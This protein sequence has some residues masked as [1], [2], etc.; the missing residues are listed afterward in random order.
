MKKVFIKILPL[1]IL[2]LSS[3]D[4]TFSQCAPAANSSFPWHTFDFASVTSINYS[5]APSSSITVSSPCANYYTGMK[6]NVAFCD[7]AVD[8]VQPSSSQTITFSITLPAGLYFNTATAGPITPPTTNSSGTSV[9]ASTL[10]NNPTESFSNNDGCGYKTTTVSFSDLVCAAFYVNFAMPIVVKKGSADNYKFTTS[11]A[12][13][14]FTITSN[15]YTTGTHNGCGSPATSFTAPNFVL[16]ITLYSFTAENL[17]NGTARLDWASANEV[18]SKEYEVQSSNN[19]IDF[20]TIQT[21]SSK[22]NAEGAS[23][24]TIVDLPAGTTYFRLKMADR[25]G[26]YTFSQIATVS[27]KTVAVDFRVYPNP[28]ASGHPL[29]IDIS[30]RSSTTSVQITN[31]CGQALLSQRLTPGINNI[32]TNGL[33]KGMYFLRFTDANNGRISTQKILIE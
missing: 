17:D 24:S 12:G 5:G 6:I 16:P 29:Q 9:A 25:D 21:I 11:G 8:F 32:S 26:R 30:D 33:S 22:N 14:N 20:V 7:D 10:V 18:N 13:S 2:L 4:Y 19:G 15:A 28:V 3:Q 27:N 1:I 31:A 23:Y